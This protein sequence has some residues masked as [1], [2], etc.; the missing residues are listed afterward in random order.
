MYTLDIKKCFNYKTRNFF[1][2][3]KIESIYSCNENYLK[4]TL[5]FSFL[6]MKL[7]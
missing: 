4:S 7:K 3:S 2:E 1:I 6:Y 5:F